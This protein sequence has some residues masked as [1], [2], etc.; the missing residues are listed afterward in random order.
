MLHSLPAASLEHRV[1]YR[2]VK[3]WQAGVQH[4]TTGFLEVPFN[5]PISS[6]IHRSITHANY[7][8][9]RFFVSTPTA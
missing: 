8:I 9:T 2:S 3:L 6:R 5:R 7:G 4:D 1:R